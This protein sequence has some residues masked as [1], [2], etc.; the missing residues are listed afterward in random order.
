MTIGEL[1]KKTGVKADMLRRLMDKGIIPCRRPPGFHR[2]I[3][4][5]AIPDVLAK[6]VEFGLIEPAKKTKKG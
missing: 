5:S 1:S 6:L 4:D 2:R 3:P